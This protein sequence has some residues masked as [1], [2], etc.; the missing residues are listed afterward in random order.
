MDRAPTTG[1]RNPD[2]APANE[3][4]LTECLLPAEEPLTGRVPAVTRNYICHLK[5]EILK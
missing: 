4:I 3:A 2:P 5:E 1:R